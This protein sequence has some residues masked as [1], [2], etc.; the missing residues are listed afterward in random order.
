MPGLTRRLASVGRHIVAGVP[1]IVY[2]REVDAPEAAFFIGGAHDVAADIAL[3]IVRT[4]PVSEPILRTVRMHVQGSPEPRNLP[5]ASLVAHIDEVHIAERTLAKLVAADDGLDAAA[6][7][8]IHETPAMRLAR[9]RRHGDGGGGR[10]IL[11]HRIERRTVLLIRPVDLADSL[12][13]ADIADI[14]DDETLVAHRQIA[15]VMPD[16]HVMDHDSG[17]RQAELGRG[18]R[19]ARWVLR[20]P[21]GPLRHFI[22]GLSH[23]LIP[24]PRYVRRVS[25]VRD[26]TDLENFS[27][28]SVRP[29]G[30]KCESAARILVNPQAVERRSHGRMYVGRLVGSQSDRRARI[31]DI[32]GFKRPASL[33]D[34]NVA[35]LDVDVLRLVGGERWHHWRM[36]RRQI[37]RAPERAHPPTM[38]DHDDGPPHSAVSAVSKPAPSLIDNSKFIGLI[39]AFGAGLTWEPHIVETEDLETCYIPVA[40]LHQW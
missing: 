11:D 20:G 10:R 30:G 24:P 32:P 2:I 33:D 4:H 28:E 27:D 14:Q 8:G 35:A 38:G 16:G 5:R 22:L 7:L 12:R 23:S 18:F 37:W 6:A 25:S 29:E 19:A 9:Q 31:A 21:P 39:P 36:W 34:Q 40:R 17:C 3:D 13:I 26:V 15:A 1:R